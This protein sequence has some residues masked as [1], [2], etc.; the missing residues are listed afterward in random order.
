MT[1][2]EATPPQADAMPDDA[3][4][5]RVVKRVPKFIPA[6]QGFP[7][8]EA[9]APSGPERKDAEDENHP[10]RVS[11]WDQSRTSN[12]QA[13]EFRRKDAFVK[14]GEPA[15]TYAIYM[16]QHDLIAHVRAIMPEPRLGLVRDIRDYNVGPGADGHCGIEGLDTPKGVNKNFARAVREEL[17]RWCIE[18]PV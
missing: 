6:G 1:E 2:S 5:V 4:V 9:F 12:A 11:V 3:R 14:P 18:E 17:A 10:V 8:S 16:I 15:P 7:T 13:V